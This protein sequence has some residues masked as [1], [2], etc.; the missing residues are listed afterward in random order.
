MRSDPDLIRAIAGRD[1]G[2]FEELYDRYHRPALGLAYRIVGDPAQAEEVVQDAFLSVWRRAGSFQAGRGE[3]RTWFF[4]IVHHQA[5]DQVRRRRSQGPVGPLT[6]KDA[7]RLDPVQVD[8]PDA[9]DR[10]LRRERVIEAVS[11]LPAE[12]RQALELAYFGGYT[13]HEVAD[14]TG[15]PLGTAK[16]RIRLGM[17]KLRD[18]LADLGRG[19]GVP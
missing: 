5:I 2:A 10:S 16:G 19:E 3:A 8:P 15:V 13:Y 18:W 14:L 11:R 17:Q 7:N 6:E 9:V 1:P 4:A 12:Q